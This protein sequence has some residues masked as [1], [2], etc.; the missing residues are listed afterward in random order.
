MV[1][2]FRKKKK[3][4]E[5]EPIPEELRIGR[6]RPVPPELEK[7]KLKGPIEETLAG[8][9][10][11]EEIGRPLMPGPPTP[12]PFRPAPRAERPAPRAEPGDKIDLILSKLET[13][14][15]R[16]RVIEE[17]LKRF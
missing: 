15:A 16:L 5:P 13:I 17:K 10:P 14:D 4:E 9:A 8:K 7:F 1:F 12:P 6:E 2:P 3:K 11:E